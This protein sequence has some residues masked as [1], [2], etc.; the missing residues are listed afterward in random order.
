MK[1]LRNLEDQLRANTIDLIFVGLIMAA[2]VFA[3]GGIKSGFE[4]RYSVAGHGGSRKVDL[5]KVKKQISEGELSSRKALF[6]R[7]APQ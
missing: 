1:Y 7:K 4:R 5:A 3:T 2:L 6:Y